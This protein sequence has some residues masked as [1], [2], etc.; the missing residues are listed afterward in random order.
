MNSARVAQQSTNTLYFRAVTSA[1]V[2]ISFRQILTGFPRSIT[3]TRYNIHGPKWRGYRRKAGGRWFPAEKRV[4]KK[5]GEKKAKIAR[6][7]ELDTRNFA[8]PDTNKLAC[9]R[10]PSS[11]PPRRPN[12]FLPASELFRWIWINVRGEREPW[13]SDEKI[14][15]E[16]NAL[17]ASTD[18]DH[19]GAAIMTH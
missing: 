15:R 11:P 6:V 19:N 10:I 13:Y 14:F 7:Y 12:V 5:G 1:L 8:R 9:S 17:P 4:V 16:R 2:I 3:F 18:E